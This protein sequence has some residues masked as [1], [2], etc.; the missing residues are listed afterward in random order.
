MT[1]THWITSSLLVARASPPIIAPMVKPM[2]S[3]LRMKAS[4]RTRS[5]REKTFSV[6]AP[7]AAPPAVP[8]ISSTTTM[9]R[10]CQNPSSHG[11]TRNSAASISATAAQTRLGP[12][13]SANRPSGT[14]N[15]ND[16][17]PAMVRP[18]PTWAADSPTMWVKN[19]ALP[20]RNAPSPVAKRIDWNDS[21]R[22]R[23]LGGSIR[24]IQVG[25]DAIVPSMTSVRRMLFSPTVDELDAWLAQPAEPEPIV[26]E[27]SGSTGQPK[28]VVLSRRAV[29]ASG[30][31]T[32]ARLGGAGPWVLALPMT[33]VAGLQVACRSLAA[34]HRPVLLDDHGSLA[35]AVAAA[36]G[37]PYVSLVATQLVRALRSQD[38]TA[39]LARCAAVLV[40]GGPVDRE[41]RERAT[42]GGIRVVATYGSAET[43]GGCVY[44]GL[45]LDGVAVA[46]GANGRIRIGGPTLFDG[47]DGDPA[48]TAD[49]LVDGW[50]LTADAGRFDEDGR[51]Q[52]LGRLDDMVISGG[53][54]VPTGIVAA[55]LREHP[56]VTAVDVGRL[57]DDEWGERV[58][59]WV[60]G[61]LSLDEARDWVAELHPRSWAPRELRVLDEM[62]M[63]RNGKV[64]RRALRGESRD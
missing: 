55:R 23:G 37:A 10:N 2:L 21:R 44:D 50:F 3:A 9:A 41:L 47:Y 28:R 36:G 22:A 7:R 59:A 43:A 12:T 15:T 35:G 61:D 29:L 16:D 57:A 26:V 63:L 24:S 46:I 4:E 31:A 20:V 45:P 62:P 49:V 6:Y 48:L 14:A 33:Y 34:G 40:G 1:G 11:H 64:D 5:S 39:A 32:A 13:R 27:T 58:V 54:K 42:D 56:A 8:N 17:R 30:T 18:R 38:D 53:V 52:V 19:T 25:T 60:V 51:L